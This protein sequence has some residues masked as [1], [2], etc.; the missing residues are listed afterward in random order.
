[1]NLIDHCYKYSA[2]VE[3]LKM[4]ETNESD[5]LWVVDKLM[6]QCSMKALVATLE[7]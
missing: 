1:M 3:K 6:E 2:T 4:I 5:A 7:S